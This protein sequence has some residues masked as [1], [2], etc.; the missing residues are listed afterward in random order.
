MG[1]RLRGEE[2]LRNIRKA[3]VKPRAN[4]RKDSL[5]NMRDVVVSN[6]H[7]LSPNRC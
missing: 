7:H 4:A 2:H 3:S 5:K 6:Q 1:Q